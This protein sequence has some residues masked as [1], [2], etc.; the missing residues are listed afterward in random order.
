MAVGAQYRFETTAARELFHFSKALLSDRQKSR[1]RSEIRQSMPSSCNKTSLRLPLIDEVRCLLCLAHFA[2]WQS[3]TSMKTEACILQSL[4][5]QTLRLSDLKKNMQMSERPDWEKWAEGESSRRTKLLAFCFL[6]LQSIA[7]DTP[8]RIWCD[9]VNLK[10]PCSCPEWTAPDVATWNL[11]QQNT[12]HEQ[13]LFHDTLE[14]LLSPV[15]Q[16]KRHGFSPVANYVLIHGILQKIVCT[17]RCISG[18]PMFASFT[19]CEDTFVYVHDRLIVS[20]AFS[21]PSY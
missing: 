8:P 14:S 2:T 19:G 6:G 7:H 16:P 18:I 9:E 5:S 10:L 4:L 3:D 13:G 21:K 12:L 20:F 17:R 1:T 11:L 15:Y